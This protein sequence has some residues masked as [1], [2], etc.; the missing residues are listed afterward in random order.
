MMFVSPDLQGW[1]LFGPKS[2]IIYDQ[3]IQKRVGQK[4]IWDRFLF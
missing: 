2:E 1:K 3:H 4:S